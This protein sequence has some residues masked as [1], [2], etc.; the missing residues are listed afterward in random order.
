MQQTGQHKH[1]IYKNGISWRWRDG[2]VIK[3][4]VCSSRVPGTNSQLPCDDL[5][6][7][8]VMSVLR[9]LAPSSASWA[10]G[11]HTDIHKGKTFTHVKQ[12]SKNRMA[13][14]GWYN[15]IYINIHNDN[16]VQINISFIHNAIKYMIT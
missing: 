4:T 10:L 14:L 16:H 12:K 15:M 6:R 1:Y 13:V 3:R 7:L 8:F 11:V 2:S 5:S 9:D